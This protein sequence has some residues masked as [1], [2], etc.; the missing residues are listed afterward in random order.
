MEPIN[1][2]ALIPDTSAPES[3][4]DTETAREKFEQARL[5]RRA[6]LRK[7]GMTSG[8]AFFGLFAVDDLARLAIKKME[9]NKETRQV[10]ETVAKEFKTAGIAFADAGSISLSSACGQCYTDAG[11]GTD[12]CSKNNPAGAARDACNQGV[13]A[14]L[15]KCLHDNSCPT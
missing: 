8:M 13:N 2:T 7:I 1:E 3:Q 15:K 10:A 11:N 4:P 14:D 12:N 5:S 6:A 9:Q